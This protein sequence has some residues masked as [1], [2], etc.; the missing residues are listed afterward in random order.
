MITVM[1]IYMSKEL[2]TLKDPTNAAY[3]KKLAF[4]NNAPFISWISKI[5][6]TLTDNAEDLDIVIPS[7]NLIEYRKNYSNFSESLWN[8]YREGSNS[9][10]GGKNNNVSYSI[11]NSKF[12]DYKTSITK[13]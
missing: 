5:N 1:H 12:C 8:Y 7:Y 10:I 9:G 3:N 2:F 6:D 4:K 13:N 11:K